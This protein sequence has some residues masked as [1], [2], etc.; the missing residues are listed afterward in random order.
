VSGEDE[1]KRDDPS[2]TKKYRQFMG[3]VKRI[4]I[5]LDKMD[6]QAERRYQM[7]KKLLDTIEAGILPGMVE[8]AD[9]LAAIKDEL[10]NNSLAKVGLQTLLEDAGLL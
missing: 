7:E 5:R 8:I 9:T 1:T 2:A 6:K 3:E 10:K 4:G